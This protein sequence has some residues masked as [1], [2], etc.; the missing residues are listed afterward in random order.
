MKLLNNI[1]LDF[2]G[3]SQ[4]WS[5]IFKEILTPAPLKLFLNPNSPP[6]FLVRFL[7]LTNIQLNLWPS[8]HSHKTKIFTNPKVFRGESSRKVWQEDGH[9]LNVGL[10]VR[11]GQVRSEVLTFGCGL[12]ILQA[13]LSLK[14]FHANPLRWVPAVQATNYKRQS[15]FKFLF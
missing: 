14:G 6:R 15:R 4:T 2:S 1:F 11:H 12:R 7:V 8:N 3:F 10:V 13:G 9:R 5:K